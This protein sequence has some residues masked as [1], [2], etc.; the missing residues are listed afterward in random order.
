M[1]WNELTAGLVK[2]WAFDIGVH[3]PVMFVPY[4]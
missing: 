2:Y 3:A 4:K 1:L